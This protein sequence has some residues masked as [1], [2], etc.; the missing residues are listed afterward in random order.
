MSPNT[1]GVDTHELEEPL[2]S[3][4]IGGHPQGLT[5]AQTLGAL[6]GEANN[7]LDWLL[8]VT[9]RFKATDPRDKLYALLGLA[10]DGDILKPDY[11][12]SYEQMLRNF[13]SSHIKRYNSLTVVLGNRYREVPSG[14]SWVPDLLHD[15]FH[16]GQG[17]IPARNNDHFRAAGS[18]TAIVSVNAAVST[19]SSGGV[20]VGEIDTVIGPL[21]VAENYPTRLSRA[22]KVSPCR[23][24]RI[25]SS[26]LSKISAKVSP[27]PAGK[28]F[29]GPCAWTATGPT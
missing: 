16:G 7:N 27:S 2:K 23:L 29:G 12:T 19:R 21:L 8:R 24:A 9:A 22:S 13:V 17:L 26:K 6:T 18:R 4:L 5:M 28:R 10:V 25:S 11:T 1:V 15:S 20:S 14:P 3:M